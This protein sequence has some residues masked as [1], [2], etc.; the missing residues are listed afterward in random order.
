MKEV[1]KHGIHDRG[2]ISEVRRTCISW[3]QGFQV[4]AG[5]V[6]LV[7]RGTAKAKVTWQPGIKEQVLAQ[8]HQGIVVFRG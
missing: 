5:V 4:A 6:R 8:R 7:T 1:L 2:S 3:A